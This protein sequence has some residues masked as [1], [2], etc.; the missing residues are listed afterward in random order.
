[1]EG[2]PCPACAAGHPRGYV[3]YLLKNRELTAL[4]LLTIHNLAFLSR[5]MD[6]LRHAIAAARWPRPRGRYARA[7]RPRAKCQLRPDG[8]RS[9]MA[10]WAGRAGTVR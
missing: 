3:R 6:D 7:P 2:C 4:R 8:Q 9:W 10:A 1:M 5:L